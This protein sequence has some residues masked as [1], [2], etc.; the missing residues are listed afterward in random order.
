MHHSILKI[1]SRGERGHCRILDYHVDFYLDH[2]E[3]GIGEG[4]AF[5]K[6]KMVW[7]KHKRSNPIAYLW[8]MICRPFRF[9]SI[10]CV[11]SREVN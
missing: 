8:G 9:A 7:A 5:Q 3:R 10:F 6:G 4:R 1:K 11:W 2:F